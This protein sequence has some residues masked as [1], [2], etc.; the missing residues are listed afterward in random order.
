MRGGLVV[1][2]GPRQKCV[3]LGLHGAGKEGTGAGAIPAQRG[4]AGSRPGTSLCSRSDFVFWGFF[5]GCS[6]GLFGFFPFLKCA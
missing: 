4:T 3:S 6:G 5:S 1:K 2:E